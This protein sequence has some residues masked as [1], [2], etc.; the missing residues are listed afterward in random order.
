MIKKYVD[1]DD[2]YIS[3]TILYVTAFVGV[4]MLEVG[5]FL[6]SIQIVHNDSMTELVLILKGGKKWGIY[7]V[8]I[9]ELLSHS[10]HS[11]LGWPSEFG[12]I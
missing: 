4:S 8:I 2:K 11:E 3:C 10:Q 12:W 1:T 6:K 5:I 9:M 7:I